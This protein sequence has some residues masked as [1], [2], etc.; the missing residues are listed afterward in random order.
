M[1]LCSH[2][3]DGSLGLGLGPSRKEKQWKTLTI[4]L[5]RQVVFIVLGCVYKSLH[6]RCIQLSDEADSHQSPRLSCTQWRCA[7]WCCDTPRGELQVKER[8]RYFCQAEALRLSSV[9]GDDS[10]WQSLA[11]LFL[12]PRQVKSSPSLP[13]PP[14]LSLA[15]FSPASLTLSLSVMFPGSHVPPRPLSP[16][17]D[18]VSHYLSPGARCSFSISMGAIFPLVLSGPLFTL[19]VLLYKQKTV[20]GLQCHSRSSAPLTSTSHTWALMPP[21]WIHNGIYL[22]LNKQLFVYS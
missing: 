17:S 10:C 15:A 11:P 13:P 2:S 18:T 20:V 6:T 8:E 12:S 19:S 16:P 4:S 1:L 7:D 5:Q 14:S 21:T 22:L 9:Q 3:G